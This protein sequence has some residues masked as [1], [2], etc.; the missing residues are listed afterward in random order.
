VVLWRQ[1]L[2]EEGLAGLE[3]RARTPPPR[4]TVTDAVR[5]EILTAALTLPPA[6]LS[7]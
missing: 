3:D 6:E 2:A 7:R 1:R 5:D 4:T